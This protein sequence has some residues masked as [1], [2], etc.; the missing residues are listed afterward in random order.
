MPEIEVVYILPNPDEP[1]IRRMPR[2]VDGGLSTAATIHNRTVSCVMDK[3]ARSL[4][5]YI[6]STNLHTVALDCFWDSSFAGFWIEKLDKDTH[7][8]LYS[9]KKP[10][11]PKN[12]YAAMKAQRTRFFC[13]IRNISEEQIEQILKKFFAEENQQKDL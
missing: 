5:L 4:A 2:I 1:P 8:E 3:K 6:N 9:L 10:L 11:S 13:S 12:I 7:K